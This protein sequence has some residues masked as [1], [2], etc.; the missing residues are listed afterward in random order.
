MEG[1]KGLPP[2]DLIPYY[3]S[4]GWNSVQAVNKYVEEP[5]GPLKNG[6]DPGVLLFGSVK[7]GSGGY[8]KKTGQHIRLKPDELLVIPVWQIFG[9]EELSSRGEAILKRTSKPFIII[10]ENEIRRMALSENVMHQLKVNKINI[11]VIIKTDN[12]VPDGV[13]GLSSGIPGVVYLNLPC[14]GKLIKTAGRQ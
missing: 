8:F 11:N 10:N 7:T 1:Y 12:S 9:S 4:P 13:A 3:W 6:G 14:P 2:S 5:N